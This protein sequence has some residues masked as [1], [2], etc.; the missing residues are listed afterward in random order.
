MPGRNF[1]QCFFAA[2]SLY[3]VQSGSAILSLNESVTTVKSGEVVLIKQHSKLDIQ[4]LKSKD[5]TDFRSIIFYLFPDFVTAFIKQTRT[6]K[7][8]TDSIPASIIHLGKHLH[9]KDFFESLLPLF[10]K[11]RLVITMVFSQYAKA[12]PGTAW[13]IPFSA[14][15]QSNEGL[16]REVKF[17]SEAEG[18]RGGCISI[19]KDGQA[20]EAW[21]VIGLLLNNKTVAPVKR[22]ELL[23]WWEE[24]L[25]KDPNFQYLQPND[26]R[27]GKENSCLNKVGLL[28]V[29]WVKVINK[30]DEPLLDKFD[31]LLATATRP[32][33]PN[34][35]TSAQIAEN[36]VGDQQRNYFR[37]NYKHKITTWQDEK[38]LSLLPA[39]NR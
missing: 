12:R 20:W 1:Q 30:K 2:N 36:V 5:G 35:P 31:F 7:S 19:R 14:K 21:S 39:K 25:K 3:Y 33:L 9:L 8:Q 38:V 26:Y 17:L 16:L 37:N 28:N 11:K 23:K 32:N 15:I 34:Y 24:H 22:K 10:E 29:P 13:A 4:K 27:I 18:M 6:I